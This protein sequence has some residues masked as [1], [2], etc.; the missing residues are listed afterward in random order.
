MVDL[1]LAELRDRFQRLGVAEADAAAAA[2]YE[3]ESDAPALATET[4]LKLCW[5]RLIDVHNRPGA[6]SGMPAARRLGNAGASI[7]DLRLFARGVAFETLFGL[8]YLLSEGPN[9]ALREALGIEDG[10]YPG[11]SLVETDAE[12]APT[13]RT[14][15]CVYE[16]L[17]VSD[18]SGNEGRDFLE[19]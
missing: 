5:H 17:R 8:F 18:P 6:L 10:G 1:S 11:W 7:D 13:G 14:L 19:D 2:A 4:L 16:G 12:G 15:D 3:V 9:H